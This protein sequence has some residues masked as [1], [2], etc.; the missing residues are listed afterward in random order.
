MS[1]TSHIPTALF[2][3]FVIP[4]ILAHG[5]EV[6]AEPHE[7]V[8]T[9]NTQSTSTITIIPASKAEGGVEVF[10]FALSRELEQSKETLTIIDRSN[11]HVIL[12]EH[13]LN[14]EE[15]VRDPVARGAMLG[16]RYLIY[17]DY[18]G[19]GYP[20]R[21]SFLCI[22]VASGNVFL[23][24]I[25]AVGAE[26]EVQILLDVAKKVAT[27]IIGKIQDCK[28]ETILPTA[29]VLNVSNKSP[30][31]RM[32]FLEDALRGVC[33]RIL[34]AKGF[35]ILRR[36]LPGILSSETSLGTSGLVHPDSAVL[37]SSADL[38]V[39]VS[40]AES[41]SLDKPSEK[42][43]IQVTFEISTKANG[44]TET[45]LLTFSP[46]EI[47]RRTGDIAKLFPEQ[48]AGAATSEDEDLQ[49]QAE[50]AR[51]L[52][53]L[54]PLDYN[55]SLKEHKKQIEKASRVIY[56]DPSAKEAYYILGISL[57]ALTRRTWGPR[58]TREGS[59][60]DTIRAFL[61]YLAFQRTDTEKVC[62]AFGLLSEHMAATNRDH[63]EKWLPI[64]ANN[65]QWQHSIAPDSLPSLVMPA[66]YFERWWM[67]NGNKRLDFLL[68]VDKVYDR[69]KHRSVV[70]FHLAET[71]DALGQPQL[72]AEY[73]YD[74]LVAHNFQQFALNSM[75]SGTVSSWWQSD[76]PIQLARLLDHR[77]SEQVLAK[78]GNRE[79]GNSELIRIHGHT[80]GKSAD[81]Y[82][83]SYHADDDML[84]A[85][86]VRSAK[87]KPVVLPGSAMY[88]VVIRL[89]KSGLW[90]QGVSRQGKLLLFR[91]VPSGQ[92]EQVLIPQPTQDGESLMKAPCPSSS[93]VTTLAEI[94]NSVL[95]G[96]PVDGIYEYRLNASSWKRFG[97][98]DGLPSEIV[99]ALVPDSVNSCAWVVGGGFLA[100]MQE[101]EVFLSRHRV[102][103]HPTS[104]DLAG[105]K[106]IMFYGTSLPAF[107]DLLSFDPSSGSLSHLVNFGEVRQF[108]G[109]PDS[110]SR[111][112]RCINIGVYGLRRLLILEKHV[113]VA[114]GT[115]LIVLARDGSIQKVWRPATFYYWHNL[116]G[117]GTG[118]CTLPPCCIMEVVGDD[119]NPN[120][121]WIVSKHQDIIPSYSLGLAPADMGYL[122][123]TNTA[124]FV[125]AY[126]I[127]RNAFSASVRVDPAFVALE[128]RGEELFF[129]GQVFGIIPKS[130]WPADQTV[131][132]KSALIM[133]GPDTPLK[134]ATQALF[135]QDFARVKTLLLAVQKQHPDSRLI[136]EM[137]AAIGN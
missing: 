14:A 111:T 80:F 7:S 33:E 4:V 86:P 66:A 126:D 52:A 97:L 51:L 25:L 72:A 58:S 71:Y 61:N 81:L 17:A 84:K 77:R 38:A 135:N 23:E 8:S 115:E 110:L 20:R 124:C 119:V 70:P 16:A 31:R 118:N 40:F 49:R 53:T 63:P 28:R 114:N 123:E 27:E 60:E 120:L 132:D 56:L 91:L 68:W 129:T 78:I 2:A 32:D 95:F 1:V 3:V 36:Q 30:S 73:L 102:P 100:R 83:Y 109:I 59:S 136:Q 24:R 10:L 41:P 54:S 67:Q 106:L 98:R 45:R 65:L 107:S 43:P 121:A 22:E 57:D 113:L 69:K 131:N 50:A 89:L 64:L 137:I 74:G 87:I 44:K 128:P 130:Q 47:D 62:Y 93:E 34:S 82:D 117:W 108:S 26:D 116:G 105:N 42:T 75:V 133:T 88:T 48:A 11:I 99:D 85:F 127:E 104:V 18:G 92:W 122:I 13:S 37:A 96:T 5:G 9:G 103:F 19:P 76:R 29:A 101:S 112:E 35:K 55:A 15:C 134:K 125:T 90:T 6:A 94:G 12:S 46:E 79:T 39:V 21:L